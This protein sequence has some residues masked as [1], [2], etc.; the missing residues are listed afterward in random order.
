VLTLLALGL[1]GVVP[2]LLF[3]CAPFRRLVFALDVPLPP[4]WSQAV[5]FCAAWIPEIEG[6]FIRNN[7]G[8]E[9]REVTIAVAI[10][11]WLANVEAREPR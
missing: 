1:G 4:Y 10:C 8:S 5:L 11:V 9:L 2:L 3:A 6:R 7:V